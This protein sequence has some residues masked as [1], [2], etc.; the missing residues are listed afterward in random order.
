MDNHLIL[1]IADSC[2]GCISY[3][4]HDSTHNI[5]VLSTALEL[6]VLQLSAVQCNTLFCESE[7][8]FQFNL[9][10]KN[11]I[12]AD[13]SFFPTVWCFFASEVLLPFFGP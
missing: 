11:K 3:G 8:K 5:T 1:Y 7:T 4:N 2:Q 13:L 9:L 12:K 10:L 6:N